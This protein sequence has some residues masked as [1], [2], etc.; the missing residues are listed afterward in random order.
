VA[1]PKR[2]CNLVAP[3]CHCFTAGCINVAAI[4]AERE[5]V[6]ASFS[7]V[8]LFAH[9]VNAADD[10]VDVDHGG[11]K[12]CCCCCCVLFLWL[13]DVAKQ[14]YTSISDR[15]PF[16]FTDISDPLEDTL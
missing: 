3:V 4:A 5:I 15:F 12:V 6:L 11:S 9:S 16:C 2:I 13:F 10:F 14:H 1:E 7:P 8:F